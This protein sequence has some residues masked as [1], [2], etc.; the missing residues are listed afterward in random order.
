M[1]I[2]NDNTLAKKT[3]KKALPLAV[4]R[5][6]RD[7]AGALERLKSSEKLSLA[8]REIFATNLGRMF[9]EAARKDADLNMKR[10][11]LEVFVNLEV[12]E[13]AY[14][15]RKTFIW[16]GSDSGGCSSKNLKAQGH[17]YLQFLPALESRIFEELRRKE[18]AAGLDTSKLLSQL[19]EGS[20]LDVIE[21]H[22]VRFEESFRVEIDK[23]FQQCCDGV[24]NAVDL[25]WL[26]EYL[27][28][29][30]VT[31]LGNNGVLAGFNLQ[32]IPV[33]ADINEV[34]WM[35]CFLGTEE[36]S[37]CAAPCVNLATVISPLSAFGNSLYSGECEMQVDL[38]DADLGNEDS[39]ATELLWMLFGSELA[40]RDDLTKEELEYLDCLKDDRALARKGEGDF[41]YKDFPFG[42]D[43]D[44]ES[45]LFWSLEKKM[46]QKEDSELLTRL[47]V[48]SLLDF[49][50][51]F[52]AEERRFKPFI[53]WRSDVRP[54][55]GEDVFERVSNSERAFHFPRDIELGWCE[56]YSSIANFVQPLNRW[57]GHL[58]YL[59]HEGTWDY[60]VFAFFPR[61]LIAGINE[62]QILLMPSE[63]ELWEAFE[64]PSYEQQG[65]VEGS[66]FQT[67]FSKPDPEFYDLLF[68]TSYNGHK[69]EGVLP[70][71]GLKGVIAPSGT[72]ASDVLS[73]LAYA[74]AESRF[75]KRL[76][77][78]AINKFDMLRQDKEAGE[79]GYLTAIE[80]NLSKL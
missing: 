62:V 16:L 71:T 49:E 53:L 14:K 45:D 44:V 35:N 61:D 55:I 74:P 52:D 41:F 39:I 79:A 26:Y 47:G 3:D 29:A 50:I 68:A 73:N 25:K 4:Y 12:A 27:S 24:V 37:N 1:N 76:L 17:H 30:K 20:S 42:I 11:F 40:A 57:R 60:N 33:D 63:A 51:R 13:S 38:S 6:S 46:E 64:H 9:S 43:E 28:R 21:G 34:R 69:V 80:K 75:D 77:S 32:S 7:L 56:S 58:Y 59:G 78:D 70:S 67:V 48:S 2:P 54:P 31:A 22:Q 36:Q 15:K 19:I 8:D 72:L 66:E 23:R 10:F 5:S 65:L 18:S